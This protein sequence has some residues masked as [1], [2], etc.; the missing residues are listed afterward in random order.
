[1][2]PTFD[3]TTTQAVT[4]GCN[5]L[6]DDAAVIAPQPLPPKVIHHQAMTKLKDALHYVHMEEELQNLSADIEVL[7]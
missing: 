5:R 2:D 4:I 6:A 3:I 1:M 7:V